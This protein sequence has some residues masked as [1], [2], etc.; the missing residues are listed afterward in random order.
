MVEIFTMYSTPARKPLSIRF[1]RQE[2]HRWIKIPFSPIAQCLHEFK[3]RRANLPIANGADAARIRSSARTSTTT[4]RPS[5]IRGMSRCR[6]ASRVD[7]FRRRVGDRPKYAKSDG[8][9]I[10]PTFLKPLDPIRSN[11]HSCHTP[12]G[13]F[14]I[15]LTTQSSLL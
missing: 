2:E 7:W 8:T 12:L 9:Q 6:H 3:P 11:V 5:L 14:V 4:P 10:W 15:G 13:S 1:A